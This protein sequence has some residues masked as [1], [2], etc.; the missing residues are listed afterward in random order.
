MFQRQQSMGCLSNTELTSILQKRKEAKDAA[1]NIISETHTEFSVTHTLQGLLDGDYDGDK[2]TIE[3]VM[4]LATKYDVNTVGRKYGSL[5]HLFVRR[6]EYMAIYNLAKISRHSHKKLDLEIC[7][8]EGQ[9][10]LQC[11]MNNKS[12]A[13]PEAKI[14]VLLVSLGASWKT[15]DEE[16][17][18]LLH[19]LLECACDYE[20]I[21]EL[22]EKA[23]D[24]INL[25]DKIHG[26]KPF[27]CLKNFKYRAIESSNDIKL[28]TLGIKKYTLCAKGRYDKKEFS[29]AVIIYSWAIEL[30]D[31]NNT[32]EDWKFL[33]K[34]LEYRGHAHRMLKEYHSAIEN[35]TMLIEYFPENRNINFIRNFRAKCYNK[36]NMP[37]KQKNDYDTILQH[38]A[39]KNVLL[40]LAKLNFT[41]N[42][43]DEAITQCRKG[44]E[45]NL[46]RFEYWNIGDRIHHLKSYNLLGSIYFKQ[47]SNLTEPMERQLRF[48]KSFE[49]YIMAMKILNECDQ[50]NHIVKK[51][52]TTLMN[53]IKTLLVSDT[54]LHAIKKSELIDVMEKFPEREQ[55]ELLEECQIP[56]H[57][58]YIRMR[59]SENIFAHALRFFNYDPDNHGIFKCENHK[60]SLDRINKRI[61]KLKIKLGIV[62]DSNDLITDNEHSISLGK[63]GS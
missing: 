33:E 48:K 36:L 22:V 55:L 3:N 2:I 11:L 27:L 63:L 61:T 16:G 10:P 8:L 34:I 58:L 18:S 4:E 17:N 39:D 50:Q 13:F 56:E 19:K 30:F 32:D 25:K 6:N 31:K 42:K 24:I 20:I 59:F 26:M 12:G 1:T 40:G 7:N 62:G 57:P 43:L 38:H 54:D 35:Y 9:T 23:P 44:I 37:E 29:R 21:N 14:A 52:R 60:G 46:K 49:N 51:Y 45:L 15:T 41:Q 53:N 28:I 5:L 47:G